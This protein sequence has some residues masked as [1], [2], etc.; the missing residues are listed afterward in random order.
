MNV[1]LEQTSHWL[2]F[3]YTITLTMN[4][5]SGL[6]PQIVSVQGNMCCCRLFLQVW[7]LNIWLGVRVLAGLACMKPW[8]HLQQ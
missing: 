1:I 3:S 2:L 5:P 4:L 6:Y 8:F 7:G